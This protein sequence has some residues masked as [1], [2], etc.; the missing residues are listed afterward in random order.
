MH[1]D[2]THANSN[3]EAWK[4]DVESDFKQWLNE[5]TGIQESPPL[6]EEPDLYSFYQELCVLRNELRVGE[7]ETRKFLRASG[8]VYLIFKKSL[9]IS[10][11]DY[12]R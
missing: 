5:L 10:K 12:P 8:K 9:G 1:D 11:A 3:L 2:G 7:G 4:S 6:P